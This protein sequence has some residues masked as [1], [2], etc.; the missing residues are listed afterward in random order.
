MKNAVTWNFEMV[1]LPSPDQLSL[2]GALPGHERIEINRAGGKRRIPGDRGWTASV[3]VLGRCDRAK[4]Q[5]SGGESA[6]QDNV[7]HV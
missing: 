2:L 3:D 6:R 5:N 7:C 4:S 1:N